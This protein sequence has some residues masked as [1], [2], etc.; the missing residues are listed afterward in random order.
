M[1]FHNGLSARKTYILDIFYI[2]TY[3]FLYK[4]VCNIYIYILYILSKTQRNRTRFNIMLWTLTW[5]SWLQTPDLGDRISYNI[6]TCSFIWF[7]FSP[8]I[9]C[10]SPRWSA[11]TDARTCCLHSHV[12]THMS[13]EQTVSLSPA[14]TTS[15]TFTACLQIFW[16]GGVKE[17]WCH[18]VINIKLWITWIY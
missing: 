4:L 2:F 17:S 18:K 10:L 11:V 12:Y 9:W 15:V 5:C 13:T 8:L 16:G 3:I 1:W 6:N 14:R 7:E